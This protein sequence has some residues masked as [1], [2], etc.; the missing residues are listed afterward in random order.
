MDLLAPINAAKD[1]WPVEKERSYGPWGISFAGDR[2][3]LRRTIVLEG[4]LKDGA[5]EDGT[6]RF[7]WYLDL[8]T[9]APLYY[10]GYRKD[11]EVAGLGYYVWR[12]SE[13]RPGYPRWSGVPARPLRTLD[14]VGEAFVD[15]NDQHA[16]RIESGNQVGVPQSDKKL[17]RKLSVGS[18]RI[19]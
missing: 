5:F 2:W 14:Q 12:W 1:T 8:Q 10:A 19:R 15:W 7:V 4:K 13:D 17:R 6:N 16:V 18:A 9:L 11:G 3:E